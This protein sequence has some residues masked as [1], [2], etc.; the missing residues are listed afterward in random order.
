MARRETNIYHRA[1]GRWEGRHYIRGSRKYKSVYGKTYSEAIDGDILRRSATCFWDKPF[2]VRK[3][4]NFSGKPLIIKNAPCVVILH[5][6]Y[7]ITKRNRC[8]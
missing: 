6:L 4:F 2:F 8:Y 5:L 1:D 7:S 3:D